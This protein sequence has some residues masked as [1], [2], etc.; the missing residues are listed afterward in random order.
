MDAH[1]FLRW[2]YAYFPLISTVAFSLP[3]LL[4]PNPR[5]NAG[6]LSSPPILIFRIP[7]IHAQQ[8]RSPI[9][10]ILP[11]RLPHIRKEARYFY[12]RCPKRASDGAHAQTRAQNRQA[13]AQAPAQIAPVLLVG[14]RRD[15]LPIMRCFFKP[16][17]ETFPL[18]HLFFF[19]SSSAVIPA[20]LPV[21]VPKML[22]LSKRFKRENIFME[23][24]EVKDGPSCSEGPP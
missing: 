24:S 11:P 18:F 14:D 7:D 4:R 15:K 21:V 6:A 9:L 17:V 19:A 13:R 1:F 8:H 2:P 20:A 10:R 16:F 23:Y 3:A 12:R 5:R 22:L